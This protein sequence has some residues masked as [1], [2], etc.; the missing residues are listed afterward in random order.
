[1]C[2]ATL[3]VARP[4]EL[5]RPFTEKDLAWATYLAHAEMCKHCVPT[6]F[7][8][9]LLECLKIQLEALYY[10]LFICRIVDV[11]RASLMKHKYRNCTKRHIGIFWR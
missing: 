4:Y 6:P 9:I 8:T 11:K 2:V 3:H 1:M 10:F 5:F 7:L